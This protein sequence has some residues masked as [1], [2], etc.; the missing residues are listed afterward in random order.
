M[1]TTSAPLP[2]LKVMMIGDM[3]VGKTALMERAVDD[4][5]STNTLNTVGVEFRNIETKV[6]D[7]FVKLQVCCLSPSAKDRSCFVELS[8][9]YCCC[10]RCC[11]CLLLLIA[12]VIDLG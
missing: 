6:H 9:G 8:N 10:C 5:F 2:V 7:Q 11:C 3:A 1:S 12:N 4:R